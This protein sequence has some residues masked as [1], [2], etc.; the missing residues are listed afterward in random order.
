MVSK[1]RI[2]PRLYFLSGILLAII[3][4]VVAEGY[5]GIQTTKTGF[6]S[7]RSSTERT[8]LV[9]DIEVDFLQ[10]QIAALKYEHDPK[11][12]FADRARENFVAID[13][14]TGKI[15]TL[16]EDVSKQRIL[17]RLIQKMSRYEEAFE[18]AT[19]VDADERV[20]IFTNTLDRLGPEVLQAL[21]KKRKSLLKEQHEIS[22]RTSAQMVETQRWMLIGGG[23]AVLIGIV[24]SVSV[25]RATVRPIERITRTTKDLAESG[26][27]D[28]TIPL[29]SN[30][31]ETG[32]LARALETFRHG[33]AERNRLEREQAEVERKAEAERRQEM[34]KLAEDFRRDVGSLVTNVSSATNQLQQAADRMTTVSQNTG[35]QAQSAASAAEQASSNVNTVASSSEELSTSIQE[36]SG[37]VSHTSE[38]ARSARE[39]A[40]SAGDQ[41]N[42]LATAANQISDV[43]N[44]IKDI[45]EQTNLLALN[46]T[47]E[48]ARAGEAGKGFAV[49]AG[50]VKSLAN[51]TTKATDDIAGRITNIQNQTNEA[52]EAINNIAKTVRDIDESASSIASA[53]EEQ[54]AATRDISLNVQEASTGTAEVTKNI[55]AVNEGARE[56]STAAEQVDSAVKALHGKTTSLREKA[57]S[58]AESVKSG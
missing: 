31:D 18:R 37:Q 50:E 43:V 39:A 28:V 38:Q 17:A 33:L 12:R 34:D 47:I 29:Q 41:V 35:E 26:D 46:A 16:T 11:A 44:M 55:N 30:E 14:N 27:T 10:A 8:E 15:D 5:I 19:K 25:A 54:T 57:E 51:Q 6:D 1:L 32:D 22:T 52:V 58:F 49:V 4:A 42:E 23:L 7:Y 40:N 9:G 53:I 21:D 2:G 3:A 20:E 45:A 56:T 36:I 24:A 13:K 48:A